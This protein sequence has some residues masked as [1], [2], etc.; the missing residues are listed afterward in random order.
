MIERGGCV[1]RAESAPQNLPSRRWITHSAQTCHHLCG[2][3][4][5]VGLDGNQRIRNLRRLR[6]HL[7][8]GR[9]PSPVRDG[10][11][12]GTMLA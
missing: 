1:A 9:Q 6:A 5:M 4:R 10:R 8:A 11:Q 7:I 3:M 2:L 12:T